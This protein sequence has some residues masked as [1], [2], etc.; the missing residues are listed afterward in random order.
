VSPSLKISVLVDGGGDRR[1]R[2]DGFGYKGSAEVVKRAEEVGRELAVNIGDGSER[3]ERWGLAAC[4]C[5]PSLLGISLV[6]LVTQSSPWLRFRL[7]DRYA[8]DLQLQFIGG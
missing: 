4:D 1:R 3:W 6:D 5:G 7:L 2:R 8:P